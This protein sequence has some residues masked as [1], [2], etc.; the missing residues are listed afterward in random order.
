MMRDTLQAQGLP[1]EVARR[2]NNNDKVWSWRKKQGCG[3]VFRA[4]DKPFGAKWLDVNGSP[5]RN[6]WLDEK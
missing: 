5:V 6:A 2:S 3:N 1:Q 4:S